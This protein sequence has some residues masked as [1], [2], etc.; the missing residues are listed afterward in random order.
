[1][2]DRRSRLEPRW[3]TAGRRDLAVEDLAVR[4]TVPAG[5]VHVRED[6]AA[7]VEEDEGRLG[8]KSISRLPK[9]SRKQ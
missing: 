7:C 5:T 4:A 3:T 2:G 8:H 6:L 9:G 1:V